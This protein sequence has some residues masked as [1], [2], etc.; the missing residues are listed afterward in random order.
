MSL[1]LRLL[2]AVLRAV[3]KPYLRRVEDPLP[4]RKGFAFAS[5]FL[6]KPLGTRLNRRDGWTEI[7][8]GDPLPDAAVLYLHGGGYIAGSARTHRE[9]LGRLAKMSGLR[10][11]APDYRLAPEHPLPAALEDAVAAW[12]GLVAEGLSPT[13]IALA[14]DSAGGGLALAL[15]AVLC[16]RGTPPVAVVAF[17]PWTDLTASGASVLQNTADPIFPGE[18]MGD[19]TGFCLADVP[20]TDPRISPLF[21]EF[22]GAPPCLIQVG[23]TEVLRDDS[24]RMAERLR[25]FG[26]EVA[27]EV[28][29][30]CP[31]V[32]QMFGILPEAGRALKA[33][34]RFLRER[35]TSS[36]SPAGS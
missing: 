12:D 28:W 7:T 8:Q 27:L 32:W 13:R 23:S 30:D 21:A 6:I 31:H 25:G 17:S 35:L 36:G 9:L 24:V 11:V 20:P 5:W 2:N 14:G 4:L 34:A 26:A 19:L 29:P 3:V 1:R 33:A 15:L 10:I 16:A 18:R 22:P